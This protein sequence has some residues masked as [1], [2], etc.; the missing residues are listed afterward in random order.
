[1]GKAAFSSRMKA[2][3]PHCIRT[4]A[5][6]TCPAATGLEKKRKQ[7]QTRAKREKAMEKKKKEEEKKDVSKKKK[8]KKRGVDRFVL[9]VVFN[10]AHRALQ[11]SSPLHTLSL[12]FEPGVFRLGDRSRLQ[13]SCFI[14]R[15]WEGMRLCI[16]A[17]Q[18]RWILLK[19]THTDNAWP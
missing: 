15:I 17:A 7:E 6:V 8:K 1:M 16:I 19:P 2:L 9:F 4:S 5:A 13:C 11:S 18:L 3:L 10:K 14:P 12:H